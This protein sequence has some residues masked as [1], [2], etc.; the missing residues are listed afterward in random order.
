MFALKQ[1]CN[2][3]CSNIIVDKSKLN[4]INNKSSIFSQKLKYSS[5]VNTSRHN[6]STV[7]ESQIKNINVISS[8]DTS[9][10]IYIGYYSKPLLIKMILTNTQ[11]ILEDPHI[12]ESYD[13]NPYILTGLIPNSSYTIVFTVTFYSGNQ[14][15]STFQNAIQTKSS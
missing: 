6:Y 10:T 5:Y 8:T 15:T 13:G 11:D 1:I 9:A 3:K 14:Y 7:I 2:N 12:F 4:K